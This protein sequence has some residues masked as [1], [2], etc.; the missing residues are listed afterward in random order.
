MDPNKSQVD[1]SYDKK[2]MAKIDVKDIER[3][4]F[5]TNENVYGDINGGSLPG[6]KRSNHMPEYVEEE[7]YVNPPNIDS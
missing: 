7:S 3:I 2:A 4:V 5:A 1:E 6:S